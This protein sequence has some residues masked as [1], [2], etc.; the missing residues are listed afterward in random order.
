VPVFTA[1]IKRHDQAENTSGPAAWRGP[2][3][4]PGC[5]PGTEKHSSSNQNGGAL[6][7]SV[8]DGAGAAREH[9]SSGT[10]GVPGE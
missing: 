5:Q 10:P 1:S 2:M 3:V 8:R 7:V 9:V 4:H 6:P